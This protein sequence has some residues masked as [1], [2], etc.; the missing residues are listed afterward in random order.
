M[1]KMAHQPSLKPPDGNEVGMILSG[2]ARKE[3][4][5]ESLE[6]SVNYDRT[7][8]KAFP[9]TTQGIRIQSLHGGSD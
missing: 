5:K 6:M 8:M 1:R 4:K 3:A 9:N 7:G 2:G